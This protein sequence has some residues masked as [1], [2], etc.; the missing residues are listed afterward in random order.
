MA[1]SNE[2]FLGKSGPHD[3][4]TLIGSTNQRRCVQGCTTTWWG[5]PYNIPWLTNQVAPLEGA[6]WRPCNQPK[7]HIKRKIQRE[8]NHFLILPLSLPS[9]PKTLCNL[10]I[11]SPPLPRPT[12]T[13][14][15]GGGRPTAAAP[16]SSPATPPPKPQNT[17]H[18]PY[19]ILA[20]EL[21]SK[22]SFFQILSQM[23]GLRPSF[24]T[25]T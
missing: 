15:D 19:L 20:S 5:N 4:N 7:Q 21:K 9:R 8:R 10:N 13:G 14:E 24:K 22:L 1:W 12:L 11:S 6:M 16:S 23:V 2:D 3:G 25:Q 18:V 17:K